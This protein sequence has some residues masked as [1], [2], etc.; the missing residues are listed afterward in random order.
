MIRMRPSGSR[1]VG[2]FA[3]ASLLAAMQLLVSCRESITTPANA[4]SL[5][6]QEEVRDIVGLGG[7]WAMGEGINDFGRV[8]G[9]ASDARGRSHAFSWSEL[10]GVHDLG[11]LGGSFAAATA[12]NGSSQVVGWSSTVSED[13]HAFIMTVGQPGMRDLG[14][15]AG[16]I[17]SWA[18]DIADDGTVVGRW[19]TAAGWSRAFVWTPTAG[20]RE[21]PVD[22]SFGDVEATAV[23]SRGQIVGFATRIETGTLRALLWSPSG[24]VQELLTFPAGAESAAWSINN[25]G[26]VVGESWRETEPH[27]AFL[28]TPEDGVRDL[29]VLP[30]MDWSI[31]R[32]INDRD[33]IV[34]Y[35]GRNGSPIGRAFVWSA[36]D[37]MRDLGALNST[38]GAGAA[39]GAYS[40]NWYGRAAGFSWNGAAF[41]PVIFPALP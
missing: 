38:D 34:G 3:A 29:G 13:V 20:M 5:S 4:D 40:V 36:R 35:S 16:G 23:N 21:L 10:G 24:D 18:N 9:A 17:A 15:P 6:V 14:T 28:W 8:V 31:A 25:S 22:S 32:D 37:G 33:Y 30:G 41:R 2:R 19:E 11:T 12:I 39:T 7:Y 1:A 27:H 26:H